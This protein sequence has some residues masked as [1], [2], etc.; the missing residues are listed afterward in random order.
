M[1]IT[2]T[3]FVKIV[4]IVWLLSLVFHENLCFI[5]CWPHAYQQAVSGKPMSGF[6]LCQR[7]RRW[8]NNNPTLVYLVFWDTLWPTAK[9]TA[10]KH[11]LC[12][13]FNKK[14]YSLELTI[15]TKS[16]WKVNSYTGILLV[17]VS[18][19]CTEEATW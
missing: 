13:G 19:C 17:S 7:W 11:L 14:H 1:H 5:W 10:L 6:L 12:T 16:F 3:I 15:L 4:E 9:Q 8:H 2:Q 18:L